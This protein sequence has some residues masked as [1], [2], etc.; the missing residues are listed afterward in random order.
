MYASAAAFVMLYW[1]VTLPMYGSSFN[2]LGKSFFEFAFAAVFWPWFVYEGGHKLLNTLVFIAL[3]LAFGYGD[4]SKTWLR[5][6]RN[7]VMFYA[8]IFLIGKTG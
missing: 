4:M 3:G 5:Y 7:V 1:A 6:A 8:V 2:E